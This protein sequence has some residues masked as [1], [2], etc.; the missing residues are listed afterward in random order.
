MNHTQFQ[1]QKCATLHNHNQ[2]HEHFYMDNKVARRRKKNTKLK[3][4]T[5]SFRI[6][7]VIAKKD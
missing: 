2:K 1:F 3:L 6:A 7:Y 4:R 5:F